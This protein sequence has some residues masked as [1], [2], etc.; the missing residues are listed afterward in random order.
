M[1]Y[2]CIF[3]HEQCFLNWESTIYV[4]GLPLCCSNHNMRKVKR[5]MNQHSNKKI[6]RQFFLQKPHKYLQFNVNRECFNLVLRHNSLCG[7]TFSDVLIAK[8]NSNSVSGYRLIPGGNC[9][10]RLL[11]IEKQR[12]QETEWNKKRYQQKYEHTNARPK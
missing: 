1:A 6:T 8:L 5:T 12:N 9:L 10:S 11:I 7:F 3:M 4:L 2:Q